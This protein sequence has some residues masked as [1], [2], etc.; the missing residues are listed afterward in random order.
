[1]VSNIVCSFP[2]SH[3]FWS[4]RNL[5]LQIMILNLVCIISIRLLELKST[6]GFFLHIGLLSTAIFFFLSCGLGN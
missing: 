3:L 6:L 5:H 1:M 2:L 4:F